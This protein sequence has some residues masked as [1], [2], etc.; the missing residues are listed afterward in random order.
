MRL[1]ASCLA[2]QSDQVDR[3][4]GIEVE[5]ECPYETHFTACVLKD[6]LGV[7]GQTSQA[8]GSPHHCYVVHVHLRYSHY[9][10]S[11]KALLH[12]FIEHL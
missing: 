11:C 12:T 10:R 6:D 9:F 3:F 2:Q 4:V 8:V 7:V 5:N 1:L